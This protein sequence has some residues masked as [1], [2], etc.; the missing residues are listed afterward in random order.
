MTL[1][2]TYLLVLAAL[3]I[4][5]ATLSILQSSSARRTWF[6]L[7][8]TQSRQQ[9]LQEKI[10][11][12]EARLAAVGQR[13]T[14]VETDNALLEGAISKAAVA[15]S[16]PPPPLTRQ[17]VE[18][19]FQ[20]ARAMATDGDPDAALRELLWCWD[21][22]YPRLNASERSM[23]LSSVATVLGRLAERHP[24]TLA[25]LRERMEKLRGT[26]LNTPG[27][28][29]HI[30]TLAQLTRT[31]KDDTTLVA[32]YDAIPSDDRR[33]STLAIYASDQLI[34]ARRYEDALRRSNPTLMIS[35]FELASRVGSGRSASPDKFP[36]RSA[37]K[38]IEVLA[39]VGRLEVARE[40]SERVLKYDP[41]PET[42][43]L[44]QTHLKRAGQP[45]LLKSLQK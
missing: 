31:L 26:V 35:T 19:R 44:L 34:A 4:G 43:A 37:A 25:A 21:E 2:R 24:P 13:A 12:L 1:T 8:D 45:D 18:D 9:A 39:G 7:A 38:D 40:L 6:E 14:A 16:T 27:D 30:S 15:K 3:A 41:S 36:V 33:R 11:A 20:R 5:A 29:Q 23:Q 32:L 42:R 28:T 22:G 17:A 10:A